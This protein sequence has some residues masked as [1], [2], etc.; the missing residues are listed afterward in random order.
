[1]AWLFYYIECWLGFKINK[2]SEIVFDN[3]IIKYYN[4]KK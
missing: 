3:I 4:N 2:L 1:M